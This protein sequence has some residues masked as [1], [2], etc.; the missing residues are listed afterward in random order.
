[1]MAPRAAG[2]CPTALV[3]TCGLDG[4]CDGKGACD[5][6][7]AGVT[8]QAGQCEGASLSD[9]EVCDGLG[10]CRPGPATI[11]VPFTCDPAASA[12]KVTCTSDADCASGI[13]CVSGSCGPKP[14]GATCTGDSQCASGHCAD[15][16][17]CNTAC[18]GACVTCNQIGRQGS[19]WPVDVGHDDPHHLCVN[20][21]DSSCGRTGTCDG[22][23]G[24]A[25]YRAEPIC[26][27]AACA[28]DLL[29]TAGT[30]DG[31][32]TCRAPGVQACAPYRCLGSACVS[33]CTS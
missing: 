29:T 24:C 23:G 12:C 16:V 15:G 28:G 7:A 25:L 6:Y 19:C 20:E 33:H 9:I 21:G 2:T 10:R 1:G 18:R 11:C 3:S 32:G 14:P 13:K 8:C 26:G 4:T 17:C 27:V 5:K 22:I 30:C 31:L